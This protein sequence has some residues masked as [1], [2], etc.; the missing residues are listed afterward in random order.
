VNLIRIY[1]KHICK[2]HNVFP[3]QHYIQIKK[4]FEKECVEFLKNT[5]WEKIFARYSLEK[6]LIFR[7]CKELKKLN[8]KK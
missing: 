6:G 3:V 4:K 7:K 1:Y 5:E 8:I 2:C